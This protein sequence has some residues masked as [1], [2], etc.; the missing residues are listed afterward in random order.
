MHFKLAVNA[1][2]DKNIF[3]ARKIKQNIQ[4]IAHLD[5]EKRE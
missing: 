3:K 5:M 2:F 4:L 1:C